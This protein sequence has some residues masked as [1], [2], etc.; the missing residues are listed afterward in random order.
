MLNSFPWAN[1]HGKADS[2]MVATEVE[3]DSRCME[4]LTPLDFEQRGAAK[5]VFDHGQTGDAMYV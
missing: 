5:T 4:T 2:I 1:C 3:S